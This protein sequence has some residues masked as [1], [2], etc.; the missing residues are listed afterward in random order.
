MSFYFLE[1]DDEEEEEVPE[2]VEADD[3]RDKSSN[4][5][6]G[7]GGNGIPSEKFRVRSSQHLIAASCM[8]TGTRSISTKDVMRASS[9]VTPGFVRLKSRFANAQRKR[10]VSQPL[11]MFVSSGYSRG[12]RGLVMILKVF[13]FLFVCK[14]KILI[15]CPKE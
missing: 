11:S 4:P 2:P 5:G 9:P 12:V 7:I 3:F 14:T 10:S 15:F 8:K 13:F 6:V 1:D